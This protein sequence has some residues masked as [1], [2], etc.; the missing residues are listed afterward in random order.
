MNKKISS[1]EWE[2]VVR[3]AK[4]TSALS[5]FSNRMYSLNKCALEVEEITKIYI[6]FCNTTIKYRIYI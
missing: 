6:M 2:R 4:R 5:V 1:N 3:K